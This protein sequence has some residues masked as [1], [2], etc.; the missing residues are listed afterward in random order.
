MKTL[1]P[2]TAPSGHGN[3]LQADKVRLCLYLQIL[4]RSPRQFGDGI[5]LLQNQRPGHPSNTNRPSREMT[6]PSTV[7]VPPPEPA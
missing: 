1:T 3:E 7:T 4:I 5:G 6:S 2:M